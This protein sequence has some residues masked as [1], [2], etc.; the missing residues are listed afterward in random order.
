MKTYKRGIEAGQDIFDLCIQEYG[1]IEEMFRF[2]GDNTG[3]SLTS[4]LQ[5]GSTAIIQSE[6]DDA[7]ELELLQ[8]FRKNRIIVN[9]HDDAENKD[10]LLQENDFKIL[11]ENDF[12]VLL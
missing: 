11:Q 4:N 5:A 7:L 12:G 2:L 6:A 8:H 1:T 10:Y 3:L 9:N